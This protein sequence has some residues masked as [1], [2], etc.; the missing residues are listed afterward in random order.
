MLD[1]FH[2]GV[3]ALIFNPQG[4]MLVLERDHPLKKL[5][6]D[7]PGGR[8]QKGETP[9]V[10]LCREV[11]EEIG[12]EI[13]DELKPFATIL[14]EIRIPTGEESVGLIFSIF[15]YNLSAPFEPVLSDEHINFEWLTPLE[16]AQKLKAQY[17]HEF[18]K[19][20]ENRIK[21]TS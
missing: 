17:P 2:L 14:T 10:T 19:S 3:K 21:G 7:I 8:L 13:T 1:S 11:K 16:A 6:W 15:Q 18:I 5:Y 9:Q 4:K 12:L 20:L